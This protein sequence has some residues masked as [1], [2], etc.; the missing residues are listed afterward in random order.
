V[1]ARLVHL[2]FGRY[3]RA[4]RIYA[5]RPIEGDDRGP[6]R[7]TLVWVDGVADPIVASRS[8]GAIVADMALGRGGMPGDV[9]SEALA[10]LAEVADRA[11]AVGPLVRREIRNEAAIDLDDLERRARAVLARAA[12]GGG[13]SGTLF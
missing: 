10:L 5:I 7:R 1:V 13:D 2:G 3:A 11:G 9:T 12:G 8:D 4:D 6:G